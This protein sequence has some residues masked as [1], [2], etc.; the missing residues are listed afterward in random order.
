[1]RKRRHLGIVLL[2]LV[3]TAS[4]SCSFRTMAV[5]RLGDALAGGGTTWSSDDDPDLIGEALPFSL[6]LMESLLA[7]SPA[8][9]GLLLATA[10]GFTQYSYG[11][12]QQEAEFAEDDDFETAEY[13]RQRARRLYL[14]ARDYGLRGL[15]VRYPGIGGELRMN[16][17]AAAARLRRDDV[18]LAYW[19]AASWALA[20]SLSKDQPALL[21]DLPAVEALIDRAVV[22]DESWESGALHSFLISYESARAGVAGDPAERARTH[23]ERAVELSRGMMASPYVSYAE[24]VAIPAGD[25]E[26]FQRLTDA[27]LAVDVDAAPEWRLQNTIAQRRAEWLRSR[28]DRLFLIDEEET[29]EDEADVPDHHQE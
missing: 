21:A 6:K 20:I 12:V 16:A 8:H 9:R 19:T 25:L 29:E 26:A 15:E 1:M 24:A 5:N 10:S 3:V 7:E 17:P 18:P 27:A 22:L 11:W 2:C 14:R 28:L 23:F 13:L 4:T